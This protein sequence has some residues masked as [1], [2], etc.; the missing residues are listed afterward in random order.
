MP[1]PT[2]LIPA[3]RPPTVWETDQLFREPRYEDGS[4]WSSSEE[5]DEED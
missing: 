5:S 2:P 1:T 3:Q 4:P